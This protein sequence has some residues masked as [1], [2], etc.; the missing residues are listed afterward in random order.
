M[1]EASCVTGVVEKKKE[2]KETP[3]ACI[4]MG[5]APNIGEEKKPLI[6][7]VKQSM[8]ICLCISLDLPRNYKKKKRKGNSVGGVNR[9]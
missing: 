1:E 2:R 9:P 4:V 5:F 3:T 8:F 6:S 7:R